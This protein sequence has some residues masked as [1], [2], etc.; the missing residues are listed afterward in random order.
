MLVAGNNTN[1]NGNSQHVKARI[2]V[3][4][5]FLKFIKQRTDCA[6]YKQRDVEKLCWLELYQNYNDDVFKSEMHLNC[7]MFN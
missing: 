1:C 6:N 4:V 3:T 5:T 2:T 7:D